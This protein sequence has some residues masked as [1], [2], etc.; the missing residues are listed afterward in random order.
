MSVRVIVVALV[1]AAVLVPA[2]LASGGN[3]SSSYGY[4]GSAGNVQTPLQSGAKPSTQTS[5]AV[6]GTSSAPV[7]S[8]GTLPFTGMDLAFLVAGG[9]VLIAFGASVRRLSRH[10]R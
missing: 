7:K 10:P 4:G 6:K 8:T 1:A 3:G 9:V 5:G 2:A